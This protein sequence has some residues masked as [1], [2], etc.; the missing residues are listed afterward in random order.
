MATSMQDQ[1]GIIAGTDYVIC[2]RDDGTLWGIGSNAKGQLGLGSV[3][4]V[5]EWNK[6]PL[7]GVAKIFN[8]GNNTNTQYCVFAIKDN[9]D[10]Y[11]TGY[12]TT[13]TAFLG[14]ASGNT[15]KFTKVNLSNVYGVTCTEK[16][17]AFILNNGDVYYTGHDKCIGGL[18]TTATK[19]VLTRANDYLTNVI[20]ACPSY[21]TNYMCYLKSDGTW[22]QTYSNSNV[23]ATTAVAGSLFKGT[24][25]G[26]A[27]I[28]GS[29]EGGHIFFITT[30]G[31]LFGWGL[32]TNGQ[33]GYANTSSQASLVSI[34]MTNIKQIA[35]GTAFSMILKTDG[36]VWVTGLN[37]N[38]QLGIGNTTQQTSFM[39]NEMGAYSVQSIQAGPTVSYIRLDGT[40]Y[41]IRG[42]DKCYTNPA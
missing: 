5:T 30:A 14:Y 16:G 39:K 15:T 12:N 10:L 4:S 8:G 17:T 33:L 36:T 38:G 25:T 2:R 13:A 21:N 35:T 42:E 9:G 40:N 1:P 26:I 37:G 7:T 11:S 3:A 31:A 41:Y 32:N 6:L 34:S 22:Y 28:C 29:K 24:K 20:D 18:T 23:T 27:K 19:T